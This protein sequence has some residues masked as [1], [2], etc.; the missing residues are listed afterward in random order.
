M[1]S[2]PKVVSIE[3]STE[4]KWIGISLKKKTIDK[5]SPVVHNQQTLD[6]AHVSDKDYRSR[7]LQTGT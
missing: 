4:K 1:P 6:P 3:K 5:D 2:L 7:P